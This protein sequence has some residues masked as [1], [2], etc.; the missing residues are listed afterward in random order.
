VRYQTLK[1]LQQ[2]GD[3][4]GVSGQPLTEKRDSLT[5][6]G[7]GDHHHRAAVLVSAS[8]TRQRQAAL[9][10]IDWHVLILNNNHN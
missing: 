4:G 9:L 5:G 6:E 10:G 1:N 3:I 2:D 7:Q 8:A